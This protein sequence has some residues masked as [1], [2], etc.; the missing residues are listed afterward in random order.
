MKRPSKKKKEKRKAR[1]IVSY[2]TLLYTLSWAGWKQ[3]AHLVACKIACSKQI[4]FRFWIHTLIRFSHEMYQKMRI[5]TAYVFALVCSSKYALSYCFSMKLIVHNSPFLCLLHYIFF[6]FIWKQSASFTHGLWIRC[7][8]YLFI[9]A[10]LV[11]FL[12]I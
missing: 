8:I 5:T 11:R 12:I 3:P 1:T 10:Y 6:Q 9:F 2:S 4:I 7:F